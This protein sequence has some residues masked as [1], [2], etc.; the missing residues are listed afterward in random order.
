MC[1]DSHLERMFAS[2]AYWSGIRIRGSN[3]WPAI[4]H[5]IDAFEAMPSYLATKSDYYTHIMDIP[6]QYGPGYSMNSPER[7][8]LAGAID[9]TDGSWSLPLAPFNVSLARLIS[10]IIRLRH[11]MY[12][13][14][15]ACFLEFM[16]YFSPAQTWSLYT[17]VWTPE[18][19][20]VATKLHTA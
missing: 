3:R 17:R 2:V 13:Y 11:S 10:F 15:Y 18:T 16:T 19:K 14:M 8:R 4:E 6:P 9:G 7:T 12:V 20:P 5:W 1:F